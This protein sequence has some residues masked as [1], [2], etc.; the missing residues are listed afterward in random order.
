MK[1]LFKLLPVFAAISVLMSVM[2]PAVFAA[3]TQGKIT[4]D[5]VR[6]RDKATTSGSSII[7]E[8]SKGTVVTLNGKTDGQEAVSGGGK[9]WYKVTYN[10]KTG[11]VYGK[12][13]QEIAVTPT[14]TKTETVDIP[15]FSKQLSS[16][17]KSYQSALKAL[18]KTYPNW[19]FKAD[20]INLSLD[21]AID[22]EY[23]KKNLT[24]TKKWVEISYGEQWRD[25]RVNIKNSAHIRETRWT[26]ASRQ[27]IAFFMDPRNALTVTNS[28]PS[29]P[30]I[31]TFLEQSYDAKTQTEAGLKTVVSGT[32]LEKGYGSNKNAY[33]TDIMQAAKKSGVSPYVIAAT[34]RVEQ[35]VN[36]ASSLISGKYKGYEGYYNFFNFGAYGSNVVL[37][38]LKYAKN[39][40]WNSRRASI[41]GGATLYGSGYISAGQDTY[42]NMDF[43]V[44]YPSKIW[45]QYA[46]ALY[47]Q[48]TKARSLSAVCTV[49][50]K[51]HLTFKIP[52][53]SSM[54]TAVFG[55]PKTHV[56]TGVVKDK[57]SPTCT[58]PGYSGDT[59][60]KICDKLLSKGK[61]IKATGHTKGPLKN[62]VDPTCEADGYSGDIYCKTCGALVTK[63]TTLKAK[64]HVY[65]RWVIDTPATA[66]SAGRAHRVCTACGGTVQN[67][68]IPVLSVRFAGD[69]NNDGVVN[70]K[71]LTRLIKH[72]SGIS[73]SVNSNALDVNIDGVVNAKDAELLLK[74][75]TDPKTVIV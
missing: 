12:Y 21:Q 31:F 63:G 36:G 54:P 40:A 42:Y 2:A 62:T 10:S 5:A 58:E 60:C 53:Y 37:N 48:C 75:L 46:S 56:C 68:E 39:K 25:P 6:M 22:L 65:G 26:F 66:V 41:V 70:N 27:A 51:A 59:Y 45:H 32:F 52:V 61:E 47:D 72:L 20:K 29:Y 16:F 33:V 44:K 30:N 50:T 4:G 64:G 49:N 9:V 34:I 11:Y 74:H 71:D 1:K 19:V 73:A 43:N 14:E 69:I 55:V 3:A 35:G 7:C 38:G 23:S 8:L 15:D 57:K 28:K 67:Y 13:V 24:D 18:H 17:P